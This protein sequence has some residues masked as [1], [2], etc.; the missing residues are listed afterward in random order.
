MISS[1]GGKG[2]LISGKRAFAGMM[3]IFYMFI[4]VITWVYIVV[5][6]YQT[7]HLRSVNFTSKNPIV[8]NIT[9]TVLL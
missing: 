1:G 2:K 4:R 6:I 5:R 8:Q 3:K 9:N 7:V